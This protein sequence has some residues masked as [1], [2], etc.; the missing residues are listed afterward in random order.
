METEREK[1]K[2]MPV[3]GGPLRND[4]LLDVT[5]TAEIIVVMILITLREYTR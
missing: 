5:V 2:I 4:M 3:K 1:F